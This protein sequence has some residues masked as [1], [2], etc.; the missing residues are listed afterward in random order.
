MQG[1]GDVAGEFLEFGAADGTHGGGRRGGICG[2]GNVF[3]V[4]SGR[5][6]G[7][8]AGAEGDVEEWSGRQGVEGV[9]C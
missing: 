8:E 5:L 9:V 1:I 2:G 3:G 6:E 7:G 4:A